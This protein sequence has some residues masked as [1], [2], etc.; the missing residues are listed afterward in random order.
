MP[1]LSATNIRHSYGHREILQGCSITVEPGERIGLV[2]RN[3][4]GKTTFLRVLAGMLKPDLGEVTLQRGSK[5]GYLAQDPALPPDETLRGAAEA[6]FADLHELHRELDAV[7]HQ[8]PGAPEP[9]L[10]RLLARQADLE[11]RIETAGGFAIDHKIDAV[12]H[13]LGFADA[14]FTLPVSALSGGQRARVALA[15]LL[16]EDSGVILLD[17]PTN[18]LDIE[19]RLW[20]E[21]FLAD[22]FKGAVIM[23]SH[24]RYLLDRVV[25]RIVEVEQGRL[26]DYPGNYSKFRE[27]RAERRESMLRAYEK[28]QHQFKREEAFIRKYKAGQ[29]AKQAKGRESRLDRAKS[30]STLEKP[31]ELDSFRLSLPR[32]E[33]TG[34]IV[35]SVRELTKIYPARDDAGHTSDKVLFRDLTVSIG[36]GE[37]WGIVGPN[38]AGKT[39][40]VRTILGEIEPTSGSVVLGSKLKVGYFRQTH[41]GLDP[42]KPLIRQL[43]ASIIKENPDRP[44]NEQE[45][46]DLAGAFLFSGGDQEKEVAVLSGGERARLM[47][48]ALLAS[49]KNVLVLDEPTNHLDIPSA[50]RLEQALSTEAGFE[51]TLILI[52]HDRALIDATC[53]HLLVLDGHGGVTIHFGNYTQWR[54]HVASKQAGEADRGSRSGSNSHTRPGKPASSGS[55]ASPNQ[56]GKAASPAQSTSPDE[57]KRKSKF[58]WMRSEQIEARMAE[59]E[60]QLA[61]ID[62][63]LAD[64]DVWREPDRADDLTERRDELK[65]EMAELEE[66]WLRKSV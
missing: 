65:A 12:L 35:A 49:A 6:A 58:S 40:L 5:R 30:E 39:T 25:D 60:P 10:Q 33:R 32:A 54:Q 11:K 27:L 45:A 64:P 63:A 9:E 28:E 19:G 41:E 42:D 51:G 2:G 53:D 44:L 57:P 16:L 20:L 21:S 18:H 52:S 3:G 14:Q 61:E 36:R 26:I 59:L 38:G 34:D 29:R 15:R 66:E 24:D 62:E 23:I 56:S 17:E 47:L 46:R 13:G 48:A 43:Q 8:M 1:V 31:L 22:S 4:A 37:R 7:F 50:E 55:G